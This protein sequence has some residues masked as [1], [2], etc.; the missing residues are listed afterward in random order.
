[1][2]WVKQGSVIQE[3]TQDIFRCRNWTHLLQHYE[4]EGLLQPVLALQT[5]DEVIPPPITGFSGE[6]ESE[7]HRLL[8]EYVLNHPAIVIDDNIQGW[9]G[10]EEESLPSGDRADVCFRKGDSI[11]AVEVKSHISN[12]ADLSR[13][14]FQCVKY[15]AVCIAWQRALLQ[16][17]DAHAVLVIQRDLP[18]QLAELAERLSVDVR[19][20]DT[21]RK[22]KKLDI[23]GA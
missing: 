1:M 10:K 20:V 23:A 5:D 7:D 12:D 14:I 3:A 11:I 9:L 18:P 4:L 19:I 15:R 22:A 8:K 6:G 17:P 16:V 21:Q 2:S 13:G